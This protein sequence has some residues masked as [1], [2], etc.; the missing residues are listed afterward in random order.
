MWSWAW[1]TITLNS[2]HTDGHAI[3]YRTCTETY[4]SKSSCRV[5]I[6]FCFTPFHSLVGSLPAKAIGVLSLTTPLIL[7]MHCTVVD[8]PYNSTRRSHAQVEGV[9][10]LMVVESTKLNRHDAVF[11]SGSSAVPAVAT[12]EQWQQRQQHATTARVDSRLSWY[13][14]FEVRYFEKQL[15]RREKGIYTCIVLHFRQT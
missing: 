15:S 2:N 10:V 8:L 9:I 13:K 12:T 5:T 4:M 1:E 11:S 14:Y 3:Q 6:L 7:Y